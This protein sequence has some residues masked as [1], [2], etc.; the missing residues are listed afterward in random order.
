MHW[1]SGVLW[2]PQPLAS[3]HPS[4][5]AVWF[6]ISHTWFALLSAQCYFPQDWPQELKADAHHGFNTQGP[7]VVERQGRD[8]H[9]WPEMLRYWNRGHPGPSSCP[10]RLSSP[11]PPNLTASQCGHRD[12][13][14]PQPSETVASQLPASAHACPRGL[15]DFTGPRG[16]SA[17]AEPTQLGQASGELE[18]SVLGCGPQLFAGREAS[19]VPVSPWL[20][21]VP[22]GRSSVALQS[23][24]AWLLRFNPKLQEVCSFFC[25]HS[26]PGGPGTLKGHTQQ[27]HKTRS[28]GSKGLPR[29]EGWS[30]S[31]GLLQTTALCIPLT[32]VYKPVMIR[33]SSVSSVLFSPTFQAWQTWG[34]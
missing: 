29:A 31:Q 8:L 17:V 21:G 23:I 11:G 2:P 13:C 18:G 30:P 10:L 14:V 24:L 33:Q 12:P 1:E 6:L 9:F 7:S 22:V 4:C 27:P 28:T 20:P 3:E 16:L 34:T 15:C 26:H 5:V 25:V 32:S 19:K